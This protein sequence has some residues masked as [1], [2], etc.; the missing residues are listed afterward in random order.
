MSDS[1]H[2]AEDGSLFGKSQTRR[3]FLKVAGGGLAAAFV[4]L[5]LGGAARVKIKGGN[6]V[7]VWMTP[8][9]VMVQD[10]RLCVGCRRCEVACTA[11]N[12]GKMSAYISRVKINR[13][14]NYGPKGVSSAYAKADGQLGN[15]RIVGET[16]RQCGKPACGN[17][18]PVGAIGSN[19]KTGARVVNANTCIGCGTCERACP[20]NIPTIDQ[21]T[22]IS[23]KCTTCDG[24]PSCAK[25]CPTGAVRMYSF[26][27]AEKLL[28]GADAVSGATA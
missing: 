16:C 11:H 17:N 28:Y 12:D 5:T 24:D 1:P 18:C 15:Y 3:D 23:T 4:A 20:W 22:N 25:A 8:N 13:N 9:G 7:K 2:K 21:E 26:E 27:E 14:M 10:V 6:E 19:P